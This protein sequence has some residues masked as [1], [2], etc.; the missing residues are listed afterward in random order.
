MTFRLGTG[1]IANL[2]LQCKEQLWRWQE[3]SILKFK[4]LSGTLG[5]MTL[6]SVRSTLLATRTPVSLL[7]ET[8]MIR[9]LIRFTW[10]SVFA[11]EEEY[12][13]L[14]LLCKKECKVSITNEYHGCR[15]FA[16]F[17]LLW[18]MGLLVCFSSGEQGYLCFRISGEQGFL[19]F[20]L[21]TTGEGSYVAFC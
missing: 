17:L 21:T 19:D 6:L 7:S 14:F 4:H 16:P 9:V 12:L 18:W 2:F 1:K 3:K 15:D 20:L 10:V 11:G 8:K 13:G 5:E